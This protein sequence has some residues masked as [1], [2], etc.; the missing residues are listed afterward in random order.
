[1]VMA[2]SPAP[3]RFLRSAPPRLGDRRDRA[4]IVDRIA[5]QEPPSSHSIIAAT[6]VM[7]WSWNRYGR[8][9]PLPSAR[10]SQHLVA[11]NCRKAPA[12]APGDECY[13][14][15]HTPAF[16]LAAHHRATRARRADEDRFSSVRASAAEEEAAS[17]SRLRVR[18]QKFN[19]AAWLRGS[20]SIG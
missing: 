2:R 7:A 4:D 16:D 1:M 20:P 6:E 14:A 12:A 9:Y 17:R 19:P 3:V 13:G 5:E 18:L 8:W 11:Q 10:R 15:G